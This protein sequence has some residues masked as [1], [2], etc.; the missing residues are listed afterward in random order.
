MRPFVAADAAAI[1]EG[2][3][4]WDIVRWLA[5]LPW[6]YTL[7]DA[8][9]FTSS[10]AAKTAYALTLRSEVEAGLKD[11]APGLSRVRGVI[12][13]SPDGALGYWLASSL[14]G[15]GYM[16][17]AARAL[18]D[19]HFESGGDALTS[20]YHAG[21]LASAKVLAGLGF[22]ETS[23]GK[24]ESRAS[25]VVD[26][27][28]LRLSQEDWQHA[29]AQRSLRAP[30][31]D[32]PG[33]VIRTERLI[34]RDRLPEDYP[35]VLA[36]VSS[37]PQVQWTASWPYPADPEFTFRRCAVPIPAALGRM[38]VIE[39]EG[40]LLGLVSVIKGELGYM[41]N[42]SAWGQGYGAEAAAAAV[43]AAF[44]AD[45]GLDI[46][47]ASVFD[48]NDASM[49]LLERIGFK[50]S[51]RSEAFCRAQGKTLPGPDF[52]ITRARREAVRTTLVRNPQGN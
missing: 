6:P 47:Q 12:S 19:Q 3:S 8:E 41:L 4:D 27:V 33:P 52:V 1:A 43:D 20:A 30:E 2:L 18:V 25:G 28:N 17:E 34:L 14:H 40:R 23:R 5:V 10:E 35:G 21:N 9:E 26:K 46:I 11:P 37:Y 36:L 24:G 48:G 7:A 16:R 50:Q 45:P 15:M 39:R 22:A 51:S 29:K 38:L 42:S 13:I 44:A 49:R 31:F 32:A